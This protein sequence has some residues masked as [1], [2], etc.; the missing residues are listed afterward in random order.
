MATVQPPCVSRIEPL[1]KPLYH[2]SHLGHA[3]ASQLVMQTPFFHLLQAIWIWGPATSCSNTES[4]GFFGPLDVNEIAWLPAGDDYIDNDHID[5]HPLLPAVDQSAIWQPGTSAGIRHLHKPLYHWSHL[6]HATASQL[7]M[8]TPFFHLLQVSYLPCATYCRSSNPFLLAVSCP[9]DAIECCQRMLCIACFHLL[10]AHLISLL[11]VLSG[12]VELNP[13]PNGNG[14]PPSL[15]TIYQAISR[16]E[17]AQSTVLAELALIRSAQT[18]IE[19]SVHRLSARV[20]ILEKTIETHPEKAA[21]SAT[22]TDLAQ[23]ASDVKALTN[24][25]DD[26]E[27]R[28]R[29]TNILFLGLQ[30]E[31]GESWDQSE[32]H[33][34]SFCSE[35]LGISIGSQDI[36]RAHRLGRFQLGK[37]RPIIVKLAHFKDKSRILIAGPKLKETPFSVREDYSAKVRLARK[38][39]FSYAQQTNASFKIRFDKLVIG[40][41]LFTYNAETDAVVELHS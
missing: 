24:K 20:E 34:T 2:W 8:Q 41:K 29:R 17:S 37:N 39:L 25:C 19:D 27:N 16:I 1:H 31:L 33:I 7:V 22:N 36:E 21:A 28:L 5:L 35:H 9:K 23:L 18:N 15:E 40:R 12:D 11:L 13:G 10:N 4:S 14:A 32:A 3:T 30:D 26:A 38:K 6:G